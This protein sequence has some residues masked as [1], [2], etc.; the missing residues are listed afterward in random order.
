MPRPGPKFGR[1]GYG[2][3]EPKR[4]PLGGGT[5]LKEEPDTKPA[6]GMR[7]TKILFTVN[8]RKTQL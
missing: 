8:K 7:L 4:T 1:G 5:W 6:M 2:G 3:F